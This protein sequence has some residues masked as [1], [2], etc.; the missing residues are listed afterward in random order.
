MLKGR[1][2]AIRNPKQSMQF[3]TLNNPGIAFH[4]SLKKTSQE[5]AI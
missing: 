4:S 5:G 1:G 2:G 3:E